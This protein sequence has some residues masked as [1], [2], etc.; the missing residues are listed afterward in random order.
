MG[1]DYFKFCYKNSSDNNNNN[2]S[3]WYLETVL[4][5][6]YMVP[7]SIE[8][9]NGSGYSCHGSLFEAMELAQLFRSLAQFHDISVCKIGTVNFLDASGLVLRTE[10][11][12]NTGM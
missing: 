6:F 9:V 2:T 4:F 11:C 1:T 10:G 7:R 12:L 5:C 3:I 8:P